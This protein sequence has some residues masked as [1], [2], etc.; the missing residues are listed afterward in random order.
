MN[1]YHMSIPYELQRRKR[2]VF[3]KRREI[4]HV[5][6]ESRKGCGVDMRGLK[7]IREIM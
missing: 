3:R 1:G 4:E 2:E 5:K 6:Q 7:G